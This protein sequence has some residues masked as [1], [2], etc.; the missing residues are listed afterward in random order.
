M[1]IKVVLLVMLMQFLASY[2]GAQSG[3]AKQIV[4]SFTSK[5]IADKKYEVR[6]TASINGNFHLYS[7]NAGVE[8]PVPTSLVFTPNPL[9]ILEGKT[10]EIGKKITKVE[11]AW[12]GKVNFYEKTVTFVQ[13]V[14]AKTKAKSSINGKIE[15]MV[16]NDEVCLPPSETPFKIP[17]G[18]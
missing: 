1:K 17:V 14:Q 18:G 10:T 15:F 13:I 2:A 9:F 8:G 3:S 16:C 12:G 11:E 5:K 7:Q 6:M 4:W